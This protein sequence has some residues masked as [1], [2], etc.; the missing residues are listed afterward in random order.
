MKT[1]NSN[2]IMPPLSSY[3]HR[4]AVELLPNEHNLFLTFFYTGVFED[5]Q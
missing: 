4:I 3:V 2:L 1:W 5:P